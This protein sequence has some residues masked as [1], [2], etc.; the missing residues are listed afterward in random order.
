LNLLGFPNVQQPILLLV[1]TG[2]PGV[3][4]VLTEHFPGEPQ[5]KVC[6]FLMLKGLMFKRLMS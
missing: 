4:P 1:P 3:K 6:G 2:S 5:H